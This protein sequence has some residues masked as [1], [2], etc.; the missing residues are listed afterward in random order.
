MKIIKLRTHGRG[1]TT[2]LLEED[3]AYDL[4]LA[5]VLQNRDDALLPGM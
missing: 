2:S 5:L 4:N 1:T 3:V